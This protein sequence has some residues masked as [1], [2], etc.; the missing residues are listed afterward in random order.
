M[1]V[2]L[3]GTAVA[4]AMAEVYSEV[5][6]T[7]TSTRQA[8][9]GPGL[10][11]MLRDAVA[12]GF[13]VAFPAVFFVLSAVGLLDVGTAFS[14]AKWTGLGLVGFYGFWAARLAGAPPAP[15]AGQGSAGGADRRGAGAA[16]VAGP[17]TRPSP[18]HELFTKVRF[19]ETTT[20]P[21]ARHCAMM[22]IRW[23]S[24]MTWP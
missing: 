10:A 24:S 19:A 21:S 2:Q 11:H 17:L 6:G 1:A 16:Q 9:A 3:L 5:V 13:G 14:I 18:G 8:V 23:A 4:V 22:P 7:E 20:R 15:G 12:V